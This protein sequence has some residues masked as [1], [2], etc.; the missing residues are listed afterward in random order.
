[1]RKRIEIEEIKKLSKQYNVRKLIEADVDEICALSVENSMFYCYCPPDVTRESILADMK[2][3]P[4]RT[5][6]DDK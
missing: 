4:P 5:T 3:L 2:A 6:Y 1:M